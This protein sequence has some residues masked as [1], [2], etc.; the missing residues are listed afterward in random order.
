MGEFFKPLSIYVVEDSEILQ[1][2]LSSAI[3]ALGAELTGC[4]GSAQTAIADLS[5]LQPDLIVIDLSL[6]FGSGFDVL[7]TL[8][9]KRLLPEAIKVVL[10]NHA[11]AEYRNRSFE[12]G[13]S[14]F[15]A[16][17]D[18]SQLLALIDALT[19]SRRP[20]SNELVDTSR[21]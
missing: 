12:L 18:T 8:Q 4:S 19:K 21:H 16:K 10:T 1:Q 11:N 13:A 6:K 2:T 5:V 9:Q 14:H 17:T 3:T 7:R 15:F 20:P